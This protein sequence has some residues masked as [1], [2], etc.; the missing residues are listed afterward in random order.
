MRHTASS[1]KKF[2]EDIYSIY[3][4]AEFIHP[5]P[6]EFLH[7]YERPG[8]REVVGFLAS[9]LAYGRVAQILKSI[10]M[11]LDEMGNFP[12]LFLEKAS[13]EELQ[14]AFSGFKHRF[15][16]DGELLDLLY[17]LG[18]VISIHGSLYGCFMK[19]Y[20]PGRPDI[21]EALEAFV[22]EL[23]L[24]MK[25]GDNSLLPCPARQSACKRLHLFL[26]WM[27]REDAVDPGGWKEVSPAKLIV[28]LDVHMHR[29]GR[30]LGMTTRRQADLRT[31]VEI[32]RGFRNIA[33]DDPV[34]YDFSLTRIGIRNDFDKRTAMNLR[35]YCRSPRIP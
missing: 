3:H 9:S 33:P 2:L 19:G 23:R 22:Q 18:K 11:V 28:P 10:S 26:R 25:K 4:R 13:R 16:S 14:K 32:T 7:R 27:V 29:I 15:T 30:A 35:A 31:A 12:R 8:D 24:H 17:A 20:D 34:R 1:R 6:L 21:S 5:D